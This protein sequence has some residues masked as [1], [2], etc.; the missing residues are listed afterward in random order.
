MPD[1]GLRH[2]KSFVISKEHCRRPHVPSSL[3]IAAKAAIAEQAF[4]LLASLGFEPG[5]VRKDAREIW[6]AARAYARIA[7]PT[8]HPSNQFDGIRGCRRRRLRPTKARAG[9]SG[10]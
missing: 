8:R 9:S 1:F 4:A 10:G 6:A 7:K 3:E 2:Q 5:R